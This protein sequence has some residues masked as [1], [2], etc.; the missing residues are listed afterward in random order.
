M[1]HTARI[2][3]PVRRP[4][5]LVI[6][7]DQAVRSA[8][9]FAFEDQYGV[10]TCGSGPEGIALMDSSIHA[11]ILDIKL[12]GEDGFWVYEIIKKRF[13]NLP[14]I[15]FSAF[16]NLKDP[17][18]IIN[19]Y[20]PFGYV[21]KGDDLW[22]LAVLVDKAV[23]QYAD[24]LRR[25]SQL[26]IADRL[27]AVGT[28]AAG[29]A[30]EINNP[31]GY[32]MGNI[33]YVL[34]EI[35]I[36]A[37]ASDYR[38]W[39]EIKR[40]LSA[41]I[42]GAQRIATIVRDLKSFGQ[43]NHAGQEQTTD[44]HDALEL[45]VRMADN[46]IKHRARLIRDY[47]ETP[48]VRADSQRLAQIF[49]NLLVNAAQALPVGQANRHQIGVST[50]TD[51]ERH[52]IVEIWDTGPGI[53][54]DIR[55]R[56][57]DPFFTTKEPNI[58]TGL[59]LF[60]THNLVESLGGS[61]HL[62]DS[63]RDSGTMFHVVLPV[64]DASPSKRDEHSRAASISAL[65]RHRRVLLIDDDPMVGQT[66]ERL[67]STH[68]VVALEDGRAAA[69]LCQRE[70]FDVILCDVMMPDFS[71][72]DVHRA[73]AE[74]RPGMERRI[75]FLTGGVFEESVESGLARL[76]N[77]ILQKPIQRELLLRIVSTS[78]RDI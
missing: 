77:Q 8:F 11:V 65:R 64:G 60:V 7:D 72:L 2:V 22:Q 37:E 44:V 54:A 31:L 42:D 73:I 25:E 35:D 74:S 33:E 5:V 41:S 16:Q 53:P 47:S 27:A 51:D 40:A 29:A 10:V 59:G 57:F 14:I 9:E 58:G 68:D 30:H 63:G 26:L 36:A 49:L 17:Y 76:D 15:F 70:E 78:D 1:P 48:P 67:L 46:E 43:T 55:E 50:S 23:R 20:R 66:I 12:H 6:D 18:E 56:V 19:Q 39:S 13:P 24:Y 52:V 61:I 32:I 75:V 45:A 71:G 4:N 28:L 62:V 69:E 3:P 34:E 21:R 38:G